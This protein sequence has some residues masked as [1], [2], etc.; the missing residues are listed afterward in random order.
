MSHRVAWRTKLS[1]SSAKYSDGNADSA[2]RSRTGLDRPVAAAPPAPAPEY[3]TAANAARAA[4]ASAARWVGVYRS[5]SPGSMYIDSVWP[6]RC[7]SGGGGGGGSASL[8]G[9]PDGR[10]GYSGARRGAPSSGSGLEAR[11]PSKLN[12]WVVPGHCNAVNA[13]QCILSLSPFR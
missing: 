10:C 3:A 8:D 1:V 9:R 7:V 2:I 4:A 11:A 5:C 6:N 13:R 12:R